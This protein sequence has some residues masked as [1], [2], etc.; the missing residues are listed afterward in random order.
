MKESEFIHRNKD[1]WKDIEGILSDKK[2]SK[3]TDLGDLFLQVTDDLSYSQTHYPRRSVRLYLNSVAR[4]IFGKVFRTRRFQFHK[5][6]TFWTDDLPHILFEERR[7]IYLSFGIFLLALLVGVFSSFH[8]PDF[9]RQILGPDYV[10]MTEDNILRGDPLGVYK[11][12]DPFEMFLMIGYNNLQVSIFTF[13]LGM[14][15]GLGTLGILLRNGVMVGVFQYFFIEK[16]LFWP[17]FLTIWQHGTIEISCI[18]LA[19]AGGF[20]LSRGLI[21]P[22]NFPR[23]FALRRSFTRGMKIMLG[24]A[25]LI[26]L[27]AF[28]ESFFTRFDNMHW[29][30]RIS[31]I[32]FSLILILGYFVI[33]PLYKG[34]KQETDAPVDRSDLL[35]TPKPELTGIR[36]NGGIIYQLILIIKGQLGRSLLLAL[37]FSIP[38]A[39]VIQFLYNGDHFSGIRGMNAGISTFILEVILD[40]IRSTFTS[41]GAFFETYHFSQFPWFFPLWSLLITQL[42]VFS[43]NRFILPYHPAGQVRFPWKRIP[44]LLLSVSISLLPFFSGLWYLP[45]WILIL[46]PIL[47]QAALSAFIESQPILRRSLGLILSNAAKLSALTLLLTLLGLLVIFMVTS[48]LMYLILELSNDFVG[49]SE[50][51]SSTMIEFLMVTIFVFVWWLVLSLFVT[52]YQVAFFSFREITEANELMDRISTIKPKRFFHRAG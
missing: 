51:V 9:A 34:P 14:L 5:F 32:L 33:L 4:L 27:A 23:G 35:P 10:K 42:L 28:I 26:V 17:S 18:I 6:K 29:V 20:T 39:I 21:F 48:P 25:P 31:I 45:F 15:F 49:F 13:V 16:G 41:L 7:T 19:G 8:E 46:L 12:S 24:I 2:R 40:L 52:G 38:I 37:A 1:R 43:A 50:T 47:S 30:I 44:I 11:D 22:G 3:E 36:S